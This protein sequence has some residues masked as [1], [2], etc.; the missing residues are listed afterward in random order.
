MTEPATLREWLVYWAKDLVRMFAEMAAL[1][2]FVF[3]TI[4]IC[5]YFA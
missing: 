5:G 4:T 2:G 3:F 1:A